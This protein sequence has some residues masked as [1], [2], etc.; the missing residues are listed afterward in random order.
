MKKFSTLLCFTLLTSWGWAQNL[1]IVDFDGFTGSNLSTV[2]PGWSEGDGATAPIGTSSFWIRDDFGNVAA[3]GDAARIN[4]FTNTREEWILSP[5]FLANE[6]SSLEYDLALTTF[7]GTSSIN[8]GSDDLFEVR[9]TDNNWASF[10][11]LASF[12]AS[13]TISNT[14]QHE[15]IDLSAFAGS[16]IIIGFFASDG[17]VNDLEDYNIYIDNINIRNPIADDLALTDILSPI[18]PACYSSSET[19]IVEVM[20]QGLAVVNFPDNNATITVEVEGVPYTTQITTGTLMPDSS[21]EVTVTTNGDFS[22]PGE[23]N[24]LA[25]LTYGIDGNMGNDTATASVTT[26]PVITGVGLF[27]DFENFTIGS[28]SVTNPG[29]YADGWLN[30]NGDYPWTVDV[31]GTFSSNTGPEVDHTL[32]TTTGKYLYTETSSGSQGDTWEIISPCIDLSSLTA[33]G[34]DFWY[35]MAGDDIGTLEVDVWTAGTLTNVFSLSGPQ[36]TG[37]TEPWER[38]TASLLA[39]QG[40]TIQLVFR[41]TRGGG[42]EGDIAIDDIGLF[43]LPT[44]DLS[45]SAILHPVDGTVYD[46]ASI[47]DSIVVELVNTGLT[48][49]DFANDNTTV[50]A[51]VTGAANNSFNTTINSGTLAVGDTL[52]ITITTS[53]DFT[54]GGTYWVTAYPT[55]SGDGD[56]L[57]DTS[58]VNVST[59][60]T[61][62]GTAGLFDDFESFTT[63]SG[64]VTN[65]GVYANGWINGNGDYPWTVDAGGT[66]SSNTGPEVDHTLGTDEGIYLYMEATTGSQGD[67]W[68]IISPCIDLSAMTTPGLDFWY[69]MA[70]DDIGTLEIDVLSGTTLTNVFSLSGTQQSTVDDPWQ[71]G[72]A[73]LI[74]FQGQTIQL[75]IRGIKGGGFESDIA[76]DDFGLFEL[77]LIDLSVSAILHPEDGTLYACGEETD[78]IVVELVN[79]G[80]ASI[81]FSNDTAEI[82]VDVSGASSSSYTTTLNSG[83]LAVGD[84]IVV[85]ITSSANFPGGGTHI[86]TA[87]PSVDGD[88]DPLNDT[89]SI[90]VSTIP[91]ITAAEGVFEDFE[92][93]TIGSG[94]VSSPGVYANGWMDGDKDYPWTVD[95]DGTVSS[96]TGPEVDHTLG[97]AAGI[98]LYTEASSGSAG[99]IWEIISPCIDLS[100]LTAPGLEFWY[101]MA[102]DDMGTLEVDVLI[103]SSRTNIFSLSGT[104]QQSINDPWRRGIAS[105][106]PFQGQTIQLVFRGIKGGGFASDIAIDDLGFYELPPIDLSATNILYPVDETLFDCGITTDSVVVEIVNKGSTAIDFSAESADVTVELSGAATNTV[107]TTISTGTLGTGDTMVV[108]VASNVDF[109]VAGD[110][111]LKAYTTIPGD[112][113]AANDTTNSSVTTR[114]LLSPTV[115]VFED[116]ETFTTG[117]GTTSNPGVYANGWMNGDKDYPWTVDADGTGSS[118]TGPEV[119]HT[120]GTAAGI[121]LYTEASS[122]SE[123][124]IWEIISPC[125]DISALTVPGLEFWYHMAGDDMGTLEVDVLIDTSQTTIFSLSGTQQQS[126]NDPWKRGTASLLPFQGQTIQ[127][128]FRGIKGSDFASDIAIDDLG[129]YELPPLDLSAT[130][131]LYPVDES[132]FDCGITTD[133]VVVEI[134]NKGSAAIDFSAEAADVSVEL[135]GAATNS[136]STTISTGTLGTGDTMVVTVASNVDFSAAGVYDLKAYTTIPGDGDVTNDTTNSSVTTRLQIS[137]AA[138][139]F[140]DFET[141]TTGS[142]TTSSPGTTANDWVNGGANDPWTIDAGGTGS[143]NTGPEVDHTLGNSAGIYLYTEAT[144][145]STGD[146]Y[147]I[148]SPCVD[149]S[150]LNAPQL[151]FW[152]H[153][154]GEDMGTLEVDVND[155]GGTTTVWSISGEQQANQDDP[156][157]QAVVPLGAYIGK[158]VQFT[159]RGIRGTDF[160]SDI[161]ID[162]IGLGEAEAVDLALTKLETPIGLDVICADSSS[163]FAVELSNFGAD[164]LKLDEDSVI[165]TLMSSGPINQMVID[166]LTNGQLAFSQSLS[167]NFDLDLSL[168]GSYEVKAYVNAIA[169][170]SDMSND[171]I[172]SVIQVQPNATLPYY[173]TFASGPAGWYAG[174]ISSSWEF[175][176]P[177]DNVIDTAASDTNAWVTNLTGNHNANENSWVISPCFDLSKV[178]PNTS[179][180]LSVWWNAE[181]SFDGAVLQASTDQG[182]SWQNVG[183][184][185]DQFNW[186]NDNTIS[187]NPGGQQEG[188]TGRNS[189]NNGS[190]G[191][192]SASHGLDSSLIGQPQVM[193]RVAFGSDGSGQDDGFAF[194]NFAVG[195]P[196]IVDLGPDGIACIDTEL[197]AGNPGATYAWSTGATTQTIV[198][199]NT[200]G[201]EVTETFTVI[202]TDSLG[203]SATDTIV[204]TIPAGLPTVTAMGIDALCFG[205]SSGMATAVG[206]GGVGPYT[207]SWNTSPVQDSITAIG[208]G[209]GQYIVTVTDSLGCTGLDTVEIG[210]P[211]AITVAVDTTIDVFCNG[212]STGTI[213]ITAM[214][215]TPGPGYTY[216]WSNGDT[217]Q[218]LMNAPRGNYT[219]A[220]TDS[221]GCVVTQSASIG[222]PDSIM[223]TVE[224]MAQ[225]TCEGDSTG[226]LDISIS[227]GYGA[228][229]DILWSTGDTTEDV[230]GLP[231]D[232][233]TV[234]ITD[235]AGCMMAY[236]INLSASPGTPVASFIFDIQGGGVGF[237][238]TSSSVDSTT[239]YAWDFGDGGTDTIANPVHIYSSNDTFIVTL[240]ATSVCGSD[241]A[242]DSVFM[243]T[244]GIQDDLLNN[245]AVFPNPSTGIFDVQFRQLDLEGVIITVFSLDGKGV[246]RKDIGR[247]NGNAEHRVVLPASIARGVYLLQVQTNEAI[248]HKRIRLE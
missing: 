194:D 217:T 234:M 23:N 180:A 29:T 103:G 208:L 156:Y 68:E 71:R 200:T 207:Y 224:N 189:S 43:E 69:H 112:G 47:T 123:G 83:T 77:P 6:N 220:V 20:N 146:I 12:N 202:V 40:Q 119:D 170:E 136:V 75:V 187:G 32:G 56:P 63:G 96:G 13:S 129:L 182:L 110:Y 149:L 114:V 57:N 99:D 24:M 212:D 16:D 131:I 222:G 15:T 144:S 1:P 93:F 184:D 152:Y 186:Y 130:N 183:A 85:N 60:P 90:S 41:G 240:I 185:G 198:I 86:L 137:Q 80:L 79:K 135:S 167:V 214:G 206:S 228:P 18:E 54:T 33:P 117:S 94:T 225:P 76:V 111:N 105:L 108:T 223:V 87:Y 88:G 65:P 27:E 28:G 102:G 4:L 229:Y 2:F 34:L 26:I 31:D 138:G 133:S 37:I 172:F 157:L 91:T 221:N 9:V 73:N 14:G 121:Y 126:I 247:V 246:Y 215:G 201:A 92:T 142:G 197:D 100:A 155:G 39:F 42:L 147:E 120:L 45:V 192:V 124:D 211:T 165:I 141:F 101:H 145:N 116:F 227:G 67:T 55:V 109:S 122:G 17:P 190:G 36:Q 191:W 118:G 241:T 181:N 58:R 21:M 106:F 239:R 219:V 243:T 177:D 236:D 199:E 163:S 203:F 161:A 168:G 235:S 150:L 188:W 113:E 30:G 174:G 175:G 205:D 89:V 153:M 204:V 98:Y 25:Y 44:L 81:D 193:F 216:L 127:L 196:P 160:T 242:R 218:N 82:I 11:T 70:G 128:V 148:T 169:G 232:T 5:S 84:T 8:M 162:D 164:T 104:Q 132:V 50:T 244:T 51:D 61:I 35:H 97:T 59:T 19:I 72:T 74:A 3:N 238:N 78:S 38:A 209:A 173:E 230:S 226:A 245:L 178:N 159:F 143:S 95:A 154:H 46:C 151:T 139:V 107:S 237:T 48:A 52:G 176:V 231:A 195:L 179:V 62:M 53:A 140:E 49:I 115:G 248:V 171:T 22:A 125:I 10:T 158:I 64:N 213:T 210:Q 166:T 134:V 66:L 233:Y 7:S